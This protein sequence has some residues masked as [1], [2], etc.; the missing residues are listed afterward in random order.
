MEIVKVQEELRVCDGMMVGLRRERNAAV[1]KGRRE[2]AGTPEFNRSKAM[3]H[4]ASVVQSVSDRW[5][6]YQVLGETQCCLHIG[7]LDVLHF[8]YLPVISNSRSFQRLSDPLVTT[9]FH[10]FPN[11]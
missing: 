3:C 1:G 7:G 6:R 8:V 11:V 2:R 5:R 9:A 4:W 10:W